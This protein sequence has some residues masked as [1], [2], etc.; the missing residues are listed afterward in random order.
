MD[1]L[2]SETP[3]R[4]TKSLIGKRLGISANLDYNIDKLP[5]TKALLEQRVET[6]EEFQLRRCMKIIQALIDNQ[7]PIIWW[8]IQREAGIQSKSFIYIK[9]KLERFVK[10]GE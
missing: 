9:D 1:L 7:E 6:I 5:K 10:K 4:I 8:K 2:L 3:I